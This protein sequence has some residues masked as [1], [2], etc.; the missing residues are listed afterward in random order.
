MGG[1]VLDL[2]IIRVHKQALAEGRASDMYTRLIQ[3]LVS[4]G[5]SDEII[6]I[7]TDDAVRESYFK[8]YGIKPSADVTA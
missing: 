1:Q 8:L 7:A 3:Q 4:D 6:K 2:E 5:K